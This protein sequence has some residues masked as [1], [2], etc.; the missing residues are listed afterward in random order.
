MFANYVTEKLYDAST[1]NVYYQVLE[2][3]QLSQVWI[4]WGLST[5]WSGLVQHVIQYKSVYVY[6]L[7]AYLMMLALHLILATIQWAYLSLVYLGKLLSL[8]LWTVPKV[9]LQSLLKS[10]CSTSSKSHTNSTLPTSPRQVSTEKFV[11]L[12]MVC[13]NKVGIVERVLVPSASLTLKEFIKMYPQFQG[14]K[15]ARGT[16]FLLDTSEIVPGDVLTL[17]FMSSTST[18]SSTL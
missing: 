7:Y 17:I 4:R 9:T 12:R 5:A 14:Y 1:L 6:V 2:F 18:S 10:S 8:L 11:E 15:F 13:R 3:F 16:T